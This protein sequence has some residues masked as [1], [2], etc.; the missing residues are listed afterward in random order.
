MSE[1]NFS[2]PT[3]SNLSDHAVSPHSKA[4]AKKKIALFISGSIAAY[5]C[6]DLIRELRKHGA[7]VQVFASESS[8]NFVSEVSLHWTSTNPVIKSLSA[9]AEHLESDY[10]FDLFL[11]APASYNSINK[12]A[13]GIAD[14]ALSTASACALGCL[15]H[16][17]TPILIAPCMNG[18]MHNQ[19]LVESMKKLHSMG[20]QFIQPRQ[21]DGKN[22]LP[23]IAIITTQCIKALTS[24]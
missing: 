19:I 17:G 9:D 16:K 22:K 24:E 23:D 14:S 21:E 3:L 10:P 1:W 8:L 7:E 20:V 11:I 2:A 13:T 5:R 15:E 18:I 4:L 12:M 6:P